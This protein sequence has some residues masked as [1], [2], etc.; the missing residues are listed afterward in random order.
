VTVAE[1]Q[2]R[3][4]YN[5]H[6]AVKGWQNLDLLRKCWRAA[7]GDGNIDVQ[8]P[9]NQTG[10]SQWKHIRLALYLCKYITKEL[11]VREDGE[12]FV[13]RHRYRTSLGIEDPVERRSFPLSSGQ[14][15][16]RAW[17]TDISGRIGFQ[18]AFNEGKPDGCARG[19]STDRVNIDMPLST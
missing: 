13:G 18:F 8:G 1:R 9:K 11:E 16:L 5:W 19:I 3:G 2:A 15:T 10:N 17:L 14:E 7:C 4:A 12:V 6:V